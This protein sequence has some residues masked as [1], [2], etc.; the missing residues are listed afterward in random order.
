M[1]LDITGKH[2]DIN[3]RLRSNIKKKLSRIER[4]YDQ[5]TTVRVILSVDKIQYRAEATVH[6]NGNELFADTRAPD[7][8]SA[9]DSLVNKLDRQVIKH[10]EK[11]S[12]HR[13]RAMSR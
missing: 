6:V 3:D 7:I 12:R 1:H 9:I 4:H 5:I 2:V 13:E 8:Q 11:S 10:K